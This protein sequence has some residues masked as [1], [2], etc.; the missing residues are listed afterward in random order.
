MGLLEEAEREMQSLARINP[1]SAV[2]QS[3]LASLKGR[4]R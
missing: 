4:R 2:I 1:T 3:L